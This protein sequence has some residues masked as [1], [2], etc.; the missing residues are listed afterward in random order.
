MAL[1]DIA[2]FRTIPGCTI[3]YPSD[4]V[5]CERA[6]ELSANTNKIAYIRTTKPPTPV[7]YPNDKTFRIGEANIL[8]KHDEDQVLVISSGITLVQALKA[9]EQLTEENLKVR[10]MDLFTVLPIDKAGIVVNAKE[11]GGCILTVEDHYAAGGIGEAVLAAVAQ[12]V[13]ISV[14][15]VAVPKVPRSGNAEELLDYFGISA[16]NIILYIKELLSNKQNSK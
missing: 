1:E 4:A 11:C 15:V 6:V 5:S 9:E 13:G 10:V 7:I 8:R 3:F 16:S 14:K 2:M 12:E